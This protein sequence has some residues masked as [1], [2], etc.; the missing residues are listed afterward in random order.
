MKQHGFYVFSSKY[1]Q[2]VYGR[3][4]LDRDPQL[5]VL[6]F[7]A[8]P[9]FEKVP[10]RPQN[11]IWDDMKLVYKQPDLKCGVERCLYSSVSQPQPTMATKKGSRGTIGHNLHDRF[12]LQEIQG[13][14]LSEDRWRAT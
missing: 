14:A 8:P 6:N 5:W 1:F 12:G 2:I 4:L 3:Q 7:A 9:Q 13:N 11:C 10:L